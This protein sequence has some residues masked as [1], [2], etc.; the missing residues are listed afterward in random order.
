[1]QSVGASRKVFEYIDREPELST[2]GNYI[3]ERISGRIEFRNVNFSYPTR[4]NITV[5]KVLFK[6]LFS[7]KLSNYM[8]VFCLNLIASIMLRLQK[9]KFH[10]FKTIQI[11]MQRFSAHISAVTFIIA[12]SELYC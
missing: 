6:I 5:L 9:Y 7:L 12:E 2:D 3:D 10:S 11:K 8:L 4:P 1:M